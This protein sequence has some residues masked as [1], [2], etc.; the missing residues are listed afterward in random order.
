MVLMSFCRAARRRRRALTRMGAA[1][2]AIASLA[3][4]MAGPDYVRPADVVPAR[5]KEGG[6]V[7]KGTAE[8][9]KG[10]KPIAPLDEAD[11]GPWWRVFDDPPLSKLLAEVEL[12]NQNVAAAAAA[13]DQA[14]QIIRQGQSG[15]FPTITTNY[16]PT[17]RRTPSSASDA[18][19]SNGFSNASNASWELD[20]WGRIRRTIEADAASAQASAAD[21]ANAKLSAQIQL[22]AAYFNLRATDELQALYE[23]TLVLFRRTRDISKNQYS[24]GTTS[25]ADFITAD[26]QLL[27]TE[28]AAIQTGVQRAQ[29]EHAIAVLIGR[30]PSD[31]SIPK[32]RWKAKKPPAIPAGVPSELLER[33]PDIA[34]AERDLQ[35]RNAL[36]G[37]AI[38]N[39]YPRV[40]LTAAL[41]F[42]ATQP[43]PVAVANESWSL[44]GSAAQ[45]LFDGGLLDAQREAAVA[46]YGQA[47][48][49]YRQTV[50]TAFGQVEDQLATIRLTA[51]QVARLDRAVEEAR[52]AVSIY[53]NQYREG[54][55]VFTSVA[56]AQSTL[57][58]NI[59]S[60]VSARQSLYV[61]TVDLV[62][63]LGGGWDASRLPPIDELSRIAAPPP[64]VPASALAA[65]VAQPDSR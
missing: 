63:A 62:G 58:S 14:Q 61:A 37:V 45:T 39:F 54:T 27:T 18:V 52:E 44:A 56:N 12:S 51:Q 43:W 5:F 48:A 47:V 42:A 57:I 8:T 41:S 24:V 25:R 38:A 13:Y 59:R 4:C 55:V 29:F 21:L 36:I 31:F 65:S 26:N 64:P 20:V 40:S 17:R 7:A 19:Y 16:A 46:S 32:R 9:R 60:A 2:M 50:L 3:G 49:S 35:S 1:A 10:W 34:A 53:L 15:L 6:G 28:A 22:A 11:R 23:E 30:S 33:R